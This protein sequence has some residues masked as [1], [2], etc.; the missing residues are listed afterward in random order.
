[1]SAEK[2]HLQTMR[3][4]DLAANMNLQDEITMLKEQLSQV[5]YGL[6]W[7]APRKRLTSQYLGILHPLSNI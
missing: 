5:G 6:R 7:L 3:E 4:E 1:M 2:A